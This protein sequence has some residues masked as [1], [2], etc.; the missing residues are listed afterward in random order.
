MRKPA[1]SMKTKTKTKEIQP[2]K[3]SRIM[4]AET[5]SSQR[6]PSKTKRRFLSRIGCYLNSYWKRRLNGKTREPE[7]LPNSTAVEPQTDMRMPEIS[8]KSFGWLIPYSSA[9]ERKSWISFS[10]H[11]V[12]TLLLMCTYSEDALRIKSSI[13]LFSSTPGTHTQIQL[14]DRWTIRTNLSGLAI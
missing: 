13:Q 3:K 10:K 12:Q 6:S 2:S 4:V 9:V 11:H 8:R 7:C 14:S 5:T 1:I